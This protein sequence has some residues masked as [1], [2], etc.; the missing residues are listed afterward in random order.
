MDK[1][2]IKILAKELNLSTSTISRAFNGSTDINK[3]TKER[4]L[5]LAR[6]HSFLPNHYASNLRDKKTKTLAVIVPEIANDFFAQAINGI[7]EVARKHGFYLLLYRTDDV[8]E[9]EVS[10]VNYLNNGKA[11]GIIMSAS[12]E[13]NDHRYINNLA[14]KNI[15]VVFF[16][17]VYEDIDAAK[18]TTNDY[19]SSFAATEH[20]IKTGCR[21]IAYLV[22]NK[23]I[24]IGKTRMQGY[25]D[26]LQKHKI[27]FNDDLVIDCSNEEKTNQ[28]ILS[29]ALK[30]IKPDGVFSSVERLAFATYH[31]CQDLGISVPE[32][33]KMISF[34][35][36]NIAPLLSP[37]LSTITQPAFEMGVKAA[38]LFFEALENKNANMP[39]KHIVLKSKL[40]IRK[41]SQ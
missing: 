27:A 23:S 1:I 28:K 7:E 25:V 36:L 8:F 17:R 41:S 24:S 2:N 38:T 15:P 16:D 31:V 32:E 11:D 13:G 3:D 35:S 9:K 33:L 21:K 5:A 40:F 29:K 18:V 10:F 6:E 22:V 37:A 30:E 26:A 39:K 34:S 19:D 4:I 20:L 14:Q 12:G